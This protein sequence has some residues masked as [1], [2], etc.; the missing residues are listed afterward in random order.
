MTLKSKLRTTIKTNLLAA[1]LV[2][3]SVTT[4]AGDLFAGGALS[5]AGSDRSPDLPEEVIGKI[6]HFVPLD[7][8]QTLAE[9]D[10]ALAQLIAHVPGLNRELGIEYARTH[11][12]YTLN[13]ILPDLS[14]CLGGAFIPGTTSLATIRLVDGGLALQIWS[15]TRG[16]VERTFPVEGGAVEPVMIAVSPDGARFAQAGFGQSW[17]RV[18]HAT[19]GDSQLFV[20]PSHVMSCAFSPDSSCLLVGDDLGRLYL[21]TPADNQVEVFP[22]VHRSNIVAAYFLAQGAQALSAADDGTVLFWDVETRSVTRTID[23][24]PLRQYAP[25]Q[26]APLAVWLA[27]E[28]AEQVASGVCPE[29]FPGRISDCA[30]SPD[31]ALLALAYR[32]GAIRLL[33]SATGAVVQKIASFVEPR[34][35]T[36]RYR[37]AFSPDARMLIRCSG[38]K[39]TQIYNLNASEAPVAIFPGGGNWPAFSSDGNHIVIAGGRT[40]PFTVVRTLAP[41]AYRREPPSSLMRPLTLGNMQSTAF[42]RQVTA[43]YA[44]VLGVYQPKYLLSDPTGPAQAIAFSPDNSKL[45]VASARS[46]QLFSLDT[47]SRIGIRT[48]EFVRTEPNQFGSLSFSSDGKEILSSMERSTIVSVDASSGYARRTHLTSNGFSYPSVFLHG[49]REYLFQSYPGHWV[50]DAHSGVLLHWL[51]KLPPYRK[52]LAVS[53]DSRSLAALHDYNSTLIV[54][55][56]AHKTLTSSFDVFAYGPP[57]GLRN[58]RVTAAAFPVD[59]DRGDRLIL[60]RADGSLEVWDIQKERLEKTLMSGECESTRGI[61]SLAVSPDGA[62]IAA[63]TARGELT[64]WDRRGDMMLATYQRETPPRFGNASVTELTFSPDGNYLASIEDQEVVVR[65]AYAP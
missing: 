3:A 65:A 27:Y 62:L 33:H 26:N 1:A 39:T 19:S 16:E 50:G 20:F 52:I 54:Y 56:I 25:P 11:A 61:T 10:P 8:L 36:Q 59:D 53:H 48:T 5:R 51:P 13:P 6:F 49:G 45:A 29:K 15:L 47:G 42:G 17:V 24:N 4:F 21:A 2:F 18:I 28:V 41:L 46:L 58:R 12:R 9:R 40:R 22:A 57:A 60:G 43:A 55:D 35:H 44:R 38:D 63:G 37:V 23:A 7:V 31:G 64:I 34:P 14:T 30:V 32:S